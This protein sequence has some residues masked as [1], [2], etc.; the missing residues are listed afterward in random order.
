MKV[1]RSFTVSRRGFKARRKGAKSS[2]WSRNALRGAAVGRDC[3]TP[4]T[5]H[6]Q[7]LGTHVSNAE[8]CMTDVTC[9]YWELFSDDSDSR[10]RSPHLTGASEANHSATVAAFAKSLIS[11][12]YISRVLATRRLES[13]RPVRPIG[14]APGKTLRLKTGASNTARITLHAIGILSHRVLRLVGRIPR[15]SGGGARAG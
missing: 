8:S 15:D 1:L 5:H 6:T 4:Q 3:Y 13:L 14:K 7:I 12:D 11:R 10:S 9:W 2:K